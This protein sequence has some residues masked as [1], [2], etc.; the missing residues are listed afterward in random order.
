[1]LDRGGRPWSLLIA[2][3]KA[4]VEERALAAACERADIVVADRWLPRSCRPRWLK[5][6]KA[7]LARSGGLAITLGNAGLVSV[8]DKEGDH[9]WWIARLDDEGPRQNYTRRRAQ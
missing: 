8:A 3:G 7:F 9:P 1:M 5:A 6:D 2:R 4:R